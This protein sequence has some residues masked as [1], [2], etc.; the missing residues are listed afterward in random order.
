MVLQEKKS[1]NL[2]PVVEESTILKMQEDVAQIDVHQDL[3]GYIVEIT[4]ATRNNSNITLGASP[5][6]TLALTRA[7]Q[8]NAY[9][10][11][12]DYVIPDDIKDMVISVIAHRLI[13][14]PEARLN[15]QTAHSVV[16]SIIEKIKIPIL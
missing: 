1:S 15:K 3:L 13:M 4:D 2:E 12:R 6:A 16:Q 5:R 14:S 9:I 7:A 8:A 11:G 10:K